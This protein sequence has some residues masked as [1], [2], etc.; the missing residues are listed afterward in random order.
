[1]TSELPS[2]IDLW[3]IAGQSNA[4]GSG[5]CEEYAVPSD[6]VWLYSLRDEWKMAREP[7]T[8][9]RYEGKDEA[10]AIMRGQSQEYLRNPELR[11]RWAR[12]F[13]TEI[14]RIKGGAGFGLPFGKAL[15]ACTGR[16]VGLVFCAKGDTRMSE[17]D[18]EYNGHPYMALYRATIR[19]IRSVS[20]P[21][22]G[23]LWYQGESDTFDGQ[24]GLYIQRM[25]RLV[26]AF[27]RDLAMPELPFFYVQIAAC[28]MQTEQELPEWNRV[29]EFQRQL[30]PVLAPGGM[31]AAIDLPLS[32]G[33]HLSASAHERLGRRLAGL[34]RRQ[35]YGDHSLE[36]GPR[37]VAVT[38][39]EPNLLKLEYAHVNGKLTPE[40]RVA[41]F[42]VQAPNDSRNLAC[43][44]RAAGKCVLIRTWTAVPTGA[45]V[46][47]AAGL[48]PFCNLADEADLAAPAFGP[49][50]VP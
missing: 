42:V 10:F 7:F 32:D 46:S 33:I 40:S 21:I 41:G 44:A 13:P 28:F 27:R 14:V 45:T 9:D 11:N 18:P 12:E 25:K 23:I 6:R 4:A 49:W 43:N 20:R 48:A 39:S 37:P 26:A 19:R 16:P 24:S 29:Q 34:A 30:E 3:V 15:S 5:S 2:D 8:I 31:C 47:Y 35:I 50:P 36:P 38:R 1:M 17:W 22:Q